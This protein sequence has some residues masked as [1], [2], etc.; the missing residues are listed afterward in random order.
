MAEVSSLMSAIFHMLIHILHS[1]LLV[2]ANNFSKLRTL[3]FPSY[4]HFIT[5][6]ICSKSGCSIWCSIC[7]LYLIKLLPTSNLVFLR[8]VRHLRPMLHQ[9][10]ARN[11]ATALIHSKLDYCNASFLSLHAN[12]LD[13]LQLVLNSAACSVANTPKLHHINSIQKSLHWLKI[14]EQIYYKNS[15][16]YLQMPSFW[17]TCLLM[18]S[19]NISE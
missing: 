15:I 3:L 11:I 12:Q 4:W 6:F 17:L 1:Y 2:F 19:F 7:C 9:T 8:D 13:R 5:R 16:Y 18:K 10:T 14:C